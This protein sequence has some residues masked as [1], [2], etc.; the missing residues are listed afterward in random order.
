MTDTQSKLVVGLV[1]SVVA[2]EKAE[3]KFDTSSKAIISL[4]V[5][6]VEAQTK[7]TLKVKAKVVHEEMTAVVGTVDGVSDS[8]I[9]RI[10]T[11]I[12]TVAKYHQQ[13]L[14]LRTTAI[15]FTL[16]QQVVELLDGKFI[17]KS[18]VDKTAQLKDDVKYAKALKDICTAGAYKELVGSVDYSML[19]EDT[20]TL[21]KGL[22]KD[23]LKGLQGLVRVQLGA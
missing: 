12:D 6:L 20:V 22:T 19:D 14:K 1:A 23:S 11:V 16:I 15:P 5:E 18:Q 7:G 8:T 17:T 2:L 3:K 9:K 13:G 21:V 10:I 4:F